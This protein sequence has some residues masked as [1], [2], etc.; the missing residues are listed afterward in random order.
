MKPDFVGEASGFY[1]C[2]ELL[3]DWDDLSNKEKEDH[4]SNFAWEPFENWDG[5]EILSAINSLAIA[6]EKM[7]NKGKE[8]ND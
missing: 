2:E 5:D 6:F 1:L 8:S 3:G 4:A 7:Y